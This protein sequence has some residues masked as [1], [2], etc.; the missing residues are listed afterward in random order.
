MIS[1]LLYV[2]SITN[3]VIMIDQ[4][5]H[6]RRM[7]CNVKY[8]SRV[9]W[10]SLGQRRCHCCGVQLNWVPGH[11][12]SASFEHLVPKSHGGTYHPK[13]GIVVCEGC[14]SKRRNTDWIEWVVRN[15]FPKKDWLI[16]K[17]IVAVEFYYHSSKLNGGLK[18]KY[19]EYMGI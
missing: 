8:K 6:N 9:L 1:F 7:K 13:N 5:K 16:A 18:R 19:E 4:E 14:N 2:Y 10:Y 12:N 11:K 15:Q 3:E 17:Y